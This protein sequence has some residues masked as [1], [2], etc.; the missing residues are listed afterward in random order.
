MVLSWTKLVLGSFALRHT[1]FKWSCLGR[2]W[3]WVVLIWVRQDLSGPVLDEAGFWV[4]LLRVRHEP[5]GLVLD[6]AG[7]G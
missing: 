7:F 4:V 6:E 2:T 1:G 3:F 5:S